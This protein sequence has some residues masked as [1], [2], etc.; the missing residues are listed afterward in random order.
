V[1]E[2]TVETIIARDYE[3]IFKSKDDKFPDLVLKN[4][5]IESFLSEILTKEKENI[6]KAAL[7]F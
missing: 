7:N 3:T 2:L 5:E 4:S 6:Q 1:K